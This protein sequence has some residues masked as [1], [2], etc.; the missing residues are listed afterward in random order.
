MVEG[1]SGGNGDLARVLEIFESTGAIMRGHFLL[2]SGLHSG[3]YL[4]CARVLQYPAYAA[5][6]AESLVMKYFA[7]TDVDVVVGPALGAVLVAHEVARALGARSM[8]TEREG[9]VMRLR[10]GFQISPGEKVLVVE[11]VIT[12]GG[13]TLEVAAAALEAGGDVVGIGALVDRRE[14]PNRALAF[15]AT[16]SAPGNPGA[17][18][19]WRPQ[20]LLRLEIPNYTPEDCPMCRRG[21]P[22]HRPGSR[23]P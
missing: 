12:T 17:V 19:S 23:R 22:I 8:F 20:A 9:G 5:F 16:V 18:K 2:T 11:D 6:L 15:P 21:E 10:R 3:T 4:Q 7:G 1:E 14:S 13:S